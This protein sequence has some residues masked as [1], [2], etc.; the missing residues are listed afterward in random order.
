MLARFLAEAGLKDQARAELSRL[1][2]Q[3]LRPE[4]RVAVRTLRTRI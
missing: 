4:M 1:E 2:Q 3:P